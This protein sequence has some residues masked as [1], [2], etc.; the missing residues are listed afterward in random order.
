LASA[1]DR[2]GPFRHRPFA[3]YW[4]GGFLSNVGTWLQTVAGSVFVYELTGSALAVGIL[5]FAGFIPI[6]LFSVPGGIISD[7]YDRRK[8]VIGF[9]ALSGV[10]ATLLALL[11]IAGA[12]NEVHVIATSFVLNTSWALA[13]PSMIALLA[14]L[15]PKEEITDAV[16]LNTLQFILAQIGGP[17]IAAGLMAT[18]GAAWAFSVN[19]LTYVAPIVAMAYLLGRGLGA[20]AVDAA[21]R[22]G[23]AAAT[24]ATDFVREQ[25]W[26]L[27][28]L[29]GVVATSAPL[30]VIRT[31]SPA[32]VVEGLGEPGSAAGLI[33]AA[34]SVGSALA[35]IV[36]VPFR[37][38][39]WSRQMVASGLVLQA[40]GVLGTAV[41]PSLA[42]ASVAVGLVG[43]G[44]SLCFPVLTGTLQA[45][46]P[47]AVRGRV[48]A[49]HQMSHLGN[50]PVTALLVG[51]LATV[52]G[53]Q[54]AVLL[55]VV[56]APIG[57]VVTRRA[58]VRLGEMGG[59][60]DV[61]MAARP[62]EAGAP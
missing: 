29:M 40:V 51:S 45:E 18:A 28:L 14:G 38:R 50:R 13:K 9:S 52:V 17:L 6:L 41:A 35:L 62:A 8:V 53:A 15:V 43:F 56:L 46:V 19:A 23:R 1:G 5:N 44:F 57:L 2:L 49:F 37:K 39:G 34:Q 55:G 27:A 24:G 30:E 61:G 58:W 60:P 12:A 36:F 11:A 31:L 20:R 32:L 33:V 26:V 21:G 10:A 48:M 3:V 47:D 59:D 25:R 7:R 22:A 4:I 42:L 54:P 16:G